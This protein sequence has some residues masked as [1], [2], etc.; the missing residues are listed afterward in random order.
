MSTITQLADNLLLTDTAAVATNTHDVSGLDQHTLFVMYSPDTDST[1]ALQ[2]TIEMSPDGTNWFP[3]TGTYSASTGTITPG[4]Q[5][6]LSFSSDGTTDQ[7]EEP[8]FFNGAAHKIR[9]KAVE[10]NAPGDYGNYS[11]WILSNKS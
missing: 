9:I 7:F 2:I 6:T 11:A 1:N 8:Y 5:V 10:T 3:F 4:T